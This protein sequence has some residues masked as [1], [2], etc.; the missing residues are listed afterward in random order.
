MPVTSSGLVSRISGALAGLAGILATARLGAA[1]PN[2]IGVGAELDAIAA[3]VIGG[4]PLSGGRVS[5]VGSV[6]GVL[7]LTVLDASFIMN[8]IN[9]TYAQ[10]LKAAFI[11]VALYLQRSGG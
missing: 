10:M 8:D 1:D 2:Y 7:L 9:A 6:F 4:T 11:I 5:V 3:A